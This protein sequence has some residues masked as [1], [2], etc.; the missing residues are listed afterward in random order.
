MAS[1]GFFGSIKTWTDKWLDRS[2]PSVASDQLA[3]LED[4]LARHSVEINAND[5]NELVVGL[6]QKHVVDSISIT[7]PNGSLVASSTGNGVSESITA[8]ALFNYVQAEIPESEVVLVK[9]K[10]WHMLFKYHGK[11]FIVK[12]PASLTTIE[13]KVIS[14]E[15]EA[16]LQKQTKKNL[17]SKKTEVKQNHTAIKN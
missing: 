1:N 2:E 10:D 4:L 8:S 11:I 15:V 14:K 3:A 13:M 16:F 5:L 7:Y 6:K 17:L 12:S 9:S